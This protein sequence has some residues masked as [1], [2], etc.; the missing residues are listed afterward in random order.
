[1]IPRNGAA[2]SDRMLQARE[3]QG[4]EKHGAA[5]VVASLDELNAQIASTKEIEL[6]GTLF[7]FTATDLVWEGEIEI[8]NVS[9]SCRRFILLT[10]DN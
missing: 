3:V 6:E 1:M 8:P 2:E 4:K 9:D 10:I 5:I 7:R